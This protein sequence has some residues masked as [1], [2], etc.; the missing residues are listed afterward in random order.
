[1]EM[2]PE[3]T[4][5]I[6]KPNQVLVP[7]VTATGTGSAALEEPKVKKRDQ[8]LVPPETPAEVPSVAVEKERPLVP[9]FALIDSHKE[10]RFYPTEQKAMEEA[11]IL[12]A[13]SG[14][15]LTIYKLSPWRNLY[16]KTSIRIEPAQKRKRKV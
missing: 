12:V 3:P 4:V 6:K 10:G 15:G 14:G 11:K 16:A 5:Y 8:E 9:Q 2:L 7:Q 1:M 13:H